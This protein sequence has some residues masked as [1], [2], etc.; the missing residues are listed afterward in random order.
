MPRAVI[1]SS[2]CCTKAPRRLWGGC[3]KLPLTNPAASTPKPRNRASAV[4]V[5]P[6]THSAST[7]NPSGKRWRKPRPNWR[8][9]C[10][11]RST[12]A[13]AMA[14]PLLRQAAG[15][16]PNC[17]WGTAGA[18]KAPA[19]ATTSGK[20]SCCCATQLINAGLTPAGSGGKAWGLGPSGPPHS[21]S[22]SAAAV[23]RRLSGVAPAAE[24]P[25][26]AA[27]CVPASTSNSWLWL[28]CS[29]A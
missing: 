4:L 3:R 19:S 7:S 23:N 24:I 11:N 1:A 17:T 25:G 26:T 20:R 8:P 27:V 18:T 29:A 28:L 5:P 15:G 10:N 21:N 2:P 12:T 13:G 14:A 9:R 22:A 16:T 6:G